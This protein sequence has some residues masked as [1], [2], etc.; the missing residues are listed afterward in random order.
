MKNL[1]ICI[2]LSIALSCSGTTSPEG[3]YFKLYTVHITCGDSLTMWILDRNEAHIGEGKGDTIIWFLD[4]S[5][6]PNCIC[7]TRFGADYWKPIQA[8]LYEREGYLL[9]IFYMEPREMCRITLHNN[10]DCDCLC[11]CDQCSIYLTSKK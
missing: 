1:F 7:I 6:A 11:D 2:I 4:E 3:D 10:L 5:E 8:V 9:D